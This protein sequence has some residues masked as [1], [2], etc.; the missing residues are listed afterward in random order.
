MRTSGLCKHKIATYGR[1]CKHSSLTGRAVRARKPRPVLQ[2][3]QATSAPADAAEATSKTLLPNIPIGPCAVEVPRIETEQ[4]VANVVQTV[5]NN[6]G[7]WHAISDVKRVEL[8][9]EV[10]A[11]LLKAATLMGTAKAKVPLCFGATALCTQHIPSYAHA[12][13]RPSRRQRVLCR[14]ARHALFHL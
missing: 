12:S 9:K 8:L 13:H 2:I 11:R 7:T 5:A 4:E 1:A 3:T 6:A 14:R 10:K